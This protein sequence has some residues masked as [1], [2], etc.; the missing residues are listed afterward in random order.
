[1]ELGRGFSRL[2]GGGRVSGHSKLKCGIP[3]SS[4]LEMS[5]H[6]KLSFCKPMSSESDEGGR[7]SLEPSDGMDMSS[8]GK[9]S[10]NAG[11]ST[12]RCAGRLWDLAQGG[13]MDGRVLGGE[14]A[15][16]S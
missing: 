2:R 16:G 5:G 13:G 12:G 9:G 8:D 1:M 15:G 4:E 10:A 6:S 14:G 3:K 7:L 11:V